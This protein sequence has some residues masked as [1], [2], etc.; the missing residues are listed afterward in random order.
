M[1]HGNLNTRTVFSTKGG[2]WKLCGLELASSVKEDSPALTQYHLL[3][4]TR[5]YSPPEVL[6]DSWT[7]LRANPVGAIDGKS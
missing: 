4:E 7:T 1:I 2:E 3:P 5:H 6:R